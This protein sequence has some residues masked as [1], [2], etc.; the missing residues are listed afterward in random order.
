MYYKILLIVSLIF[1]STNQ[2]LLTQ[3]NQISYSLSHPLKYSNERKFPNNRPHYS[4]PDTLKVI[5]ILVQFQE[6]SDPNSTGNG[7]FDLSNKYY[8]PNTQRDT[9]IGFG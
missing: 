9:V 8:N 1:F 5:A 3:D 7:K 4:T 2:L 6:D